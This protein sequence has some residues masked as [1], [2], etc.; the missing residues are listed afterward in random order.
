MSTQNVELLLSHADSHEPVAPDGLPA[1]AAMQAPRDDDAQGREERHLW[2]DGEDP[3]SLPAQR[4]GLVAPEGPEGDRLLALMEPLRRHRQEQQEGHPVRVYRV[5]AELAAEGRNL[6]DF[7]RWVRVVLDDEAVPVADRP[8]YLLFLGDFHQVPFEL[9]QAAAHDAYVGRL[10]FRRDEDYAAYVDKVLRWENAPS[11]E[12]QPRSLFFTVHD[13]TAATRTG[14][15]SLVAPAI[16]SARQ[17]RELGRF[18]ARDVLE[19]GMPGEPGANALL[20]Q[21]A[22]QDPTLLFSMSHGL[23]SPRAGWRSTDAK[24]ALQGALNLGEGQHLDGAA[25]AQ[26]P[27]LPGGI[28]FLFACFGAGTPS[29]SAFHHWLKQLQAGGQFSGRLESLTAALPRPGERPFVAALPQSVLANP[30][31]PLAVIGHVDLAWTYGFQDRDHRQGKVSRFMEP[32]QQLARGRRVGL[33]LS[34]L[35]R[36]GHQ[37]NLELTTLYDQEEAARSAGKPSTVDPLRRS[38]LWMLR[39]DLGGYVLLGDP[40]VR[41]PLAPR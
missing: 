6:E 29:R 19:L 35:L 2:D 17:A 31:G 38:H 21:A 5:S 16:A 39:Q 30:Q 9:Q 41:L 23:G 12:R 13:G 4:W 34:W 36:G 20:E 7:T 22:H 8:R 33:G 15:Q 26:R 28:W 25:L 10:A 27:F 1:D 14:Y 37:A 18:P 32:L 24:L 3:N 11:A 40:A